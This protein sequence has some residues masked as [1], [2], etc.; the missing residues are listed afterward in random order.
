M[1]AKPPVAGA[2]IRKIVGADLERNDTLS[3]VDH[4]IRPLNPYDNQVGIATGQAYGLTQ[5]L[6][7]GEFATPSFG[8][9]P[10]HVFDRFCGHQIDSTA[11]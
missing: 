4:A 7:F 8:G 11:T 2:K 5:I 6:A 10:I 1:Q 3:G 9:C